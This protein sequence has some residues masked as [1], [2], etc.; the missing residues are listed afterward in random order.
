MGG[1]G[2][3]HGLSDAYLGEEVSSLSHFCDALRGQE[4]H[5]GC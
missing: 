4:N 3:E 2:F 5:L 1:L